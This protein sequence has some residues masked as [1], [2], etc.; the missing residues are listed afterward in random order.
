MIPSKDLELC[1]VASMAGI[2][3]NIS[4]FLGIFS[5]SKDSCLYERIRKILIDFIISSKYLRPLTTAA[6][7]L[8]TWCS[9]PPSARGP[10]KHFI[11]FVD[12]IAMHS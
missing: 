7:M 5:A 2:E 9:Q 10:L 1:V 3:S 12:P 11:I 6:M 4:E 8:Y